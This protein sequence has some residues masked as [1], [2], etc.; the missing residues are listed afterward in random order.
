MLIN[1]KKKAQSTAEYVMLV[2]IVI[3]GITIITSYVKKALAG[4]VQAV[5]NAYMTACNNAKQYSIDT[6]DEMVYRAARASQKQGEHNKLDD[7]GV[8]NDKSGA[9]S[10]RTV[11]SGSLQEAQTIANGVKLETDADTWG[12][13]TTQLPDA[14][15]NG[16]VINPPNYN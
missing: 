1:L 3:G 9:E 12:K 6:S 8:A 10:V 5:S 15:A 11:V 7:Q 13:R 2:A 4:K 14:T 16:G